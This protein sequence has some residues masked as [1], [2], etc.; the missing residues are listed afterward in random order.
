MSVTIIIPTLN[1]PE[2]MERTLRYYRATRFTGGILI[3]DS[4]N[5]KH[6]ARLNASASLFSR[7]VDVR[8]IKCA[9]LNS[10]ATCQLL[11]GMVQTPYAVY[12][13]DDDI[14]LTEALEECT[15]FLDRDTRYASAHGRAWAFSLEGESP[16]GELKSVEHYP[17]PKLEES[18]AAARIKRQ[19]AD[20]SVS[21]F[22][23]HR[24]EAWREIWRHATKVPDLSFGGELLVVACSAV[25]GRSKSIATP[26]LLRE[27][28]ERR[29]ILPRTFRWIVSPDWG[30]SANYFLEEMSRRIEQIDGNGRESALEAAQDALK[31]YVYNR[32]EDEMRI[33]GRSARWDNLRRML[34]PLTHPI[35]WTLA[36][37]GKRVI[38]SVF[39]MLKR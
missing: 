28:H 31:A 3:G 23:I 9:G 8:H 1:R 15:S 33:A 39:A 16:Y 5:P 10:A 12:L 21:L 26:Y 14:L 7:D 13:G 30:P 20:Y 35:Q 17:L 11:A 27:A 29:Y 22:A 38:A 2:Y 36:A 19:F 32:I 4:S 24:T 37:E 18:T 6:F 34:W 25:L